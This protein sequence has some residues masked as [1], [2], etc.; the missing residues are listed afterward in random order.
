MCTLPT[1]TRSLYVST[2][3]ADCKSLCGDRGGRP[4]VRTLSL[5]KVHFL[6][7][8]PEDIVV[9]DIAHGLAGL[10]RFTAGLKSWYSVAEHSILGSRRIKD[11]EQ[12][13]QFLIHD[14]AEYVFGDPASPIMRAVGI[15][16]FKAALDNF[17]FF[18]NNLFLGYGDLHPSVKQL[19][20]AFCATEMHFIRGQ[21]REQVNEDY[22][23]CTIMEDQK[24]FCLPREE[25]AKW[26]L[27][28]FHFLFPEY[29][30]A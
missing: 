23:G 7:P 15:C 6:D 19:D 30:G 1:H 20:R 11:R 16:P 14:A 5:T 21:T 9:A 8:K 4:Y 12:A 18:L 24:F 28:E 22:P 26:W 3:D 25:A 29:K 13:R 2:S 27:D 10:C 17:Q